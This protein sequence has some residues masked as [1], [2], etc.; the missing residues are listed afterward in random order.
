[1]NLYCHDN[2]RSP[3]Q[4][5]DMAALKAAGVCVFCKLDQP[6][7]GASGHWTVT[8]NKYPYFGTELHLLAIPDEH[9]SDLTDLT[10]AAWADL[11]NVLGWI[12]DHYGVPAYGMC[13]RNGDPHAT[14]ATIGHVHV[15]IIVPETGGAA[16]FTI[17]R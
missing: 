11:H 5:A 7:L 14:G 13:V 9:V 8:A 4:A 3:E 1:M 17:G 15:H 2:A 12:R 10:A 6:V 16:R